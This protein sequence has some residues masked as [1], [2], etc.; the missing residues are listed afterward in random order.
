MSLDPVGFLLKVSF[1]N[2]ALLLGQCWFVISKKYKII[3]SSYFEHWLGCS[4]CSE[5]KKWHYFS[6]CQCQT[7]YPQELMSKM[8]KTY[9]SLFLMLNMNVFLDCRSRKVYW[10]NV[11]RVIHPP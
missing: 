3:S 7:L 11:A 1:V 5:W 4:A 2:A 9:I 10:A 6:W 8:V